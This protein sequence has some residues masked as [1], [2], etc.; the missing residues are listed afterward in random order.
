MKRG[1]TLLAGMLS[2]SLV[3]SSCHSGKT[4]KTDVPNKAGTV[5]F[6]EGYVVRPSVL[7]KSIKVPG[8]LR[9][10]EETVLMPDVAG[11]VVRINFTEGSFVR[12]GTLLVK[13]YDADL[14][15][16]L[17]KLNTQLAIARETLRR[18][19]ELLRVSGISELE[20]DQTNLQ[21]NSIQDDIE[22]LMA[23]ISKTEILAP[24]DGVIG[25][26]NVSLG[27]QVT[28]ATGLATI[29]EKNQLKL[30][31]SIPEKYSK[32]IVE[33]KK[34]LFTVEGDD[35]VFE[36]R[37]MASEGGI[38]SNTRNLKVR[39][40]VS[41]HSSALEPGGFAKVEVPL[42]VNPNALMI[43]TQAI[44]PQERN[45]KVVVVRHGTAQFV[46][47]ITGI[48]QASL[49]EVLNGLRAGDTVVTTGILFLKPNAVISFARVTDNSGAPTQLVRP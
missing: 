14:Q 46:T 45:K 23:Q 24:F 38:E 42:G 43:P 22:V 1:L 19:T 18:Q 37:I 17:K 21:V 33:G 36:A 39:A 5:S 4:G 16:S 11:R 47:V 12:K 28:P 15:A 41:G 29:R 3:L 6:L 2:V 7:D 9:S 48:R 26:R 32:G 20:Y 10:G 30:D 35:T 27:A 40:L 13:L 49:I 44:I 25:L 34:V 8:S 31:F